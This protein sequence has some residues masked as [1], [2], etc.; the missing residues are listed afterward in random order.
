MS[1]IAEVLEEM[2]V[3]PSLDL[4]NLKCCL[5]GHV[6]SPDTLPQ[7]AARQ[8]ADRSWATCWKHSH[9]LDWSIAL[10]ALRARVR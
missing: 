3:D 6:H 8:S 4:T 1:P 10:M 9:G 2:R 7:L 5:T